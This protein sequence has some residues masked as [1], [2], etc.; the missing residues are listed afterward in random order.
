MINTFS[1]FYDA[2]YFID[3]HRGEF[4]SLTRSI[5]ASGRAVYV[6]VL[7]TKK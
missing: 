1:N 2:T 4:I 7:N 3:L 5:S 6:V